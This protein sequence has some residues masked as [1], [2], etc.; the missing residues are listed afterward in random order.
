MATPILRAEAADAPPAS[1]EPT[2]AIG[3]AYAASGSA[4]PDID[5][6]VE[7]ALEKLGRMLAIEGERRGVSP[8]R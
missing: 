1:T 6:I 3:P 4:S 8:W 2:S 5:E 7:R